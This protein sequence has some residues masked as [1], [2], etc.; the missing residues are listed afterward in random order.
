M[1]SQ[2]L[3]NPRFDVLFEPVKIG[4]VTAPNRFYQV[5]HCTGMGYAL[6]QTL[7]AMRKV[8]AEGGWG[9]VCTEYTSIDPSSDDSPFPS[10]TLWDEDD[11]RTMAVVA[12]VI[13]EGG[14]LAGTQLWHGGLY[15]SNKGSRE[16]PIAPSDSPLAPLNP[17][18]A[19]A[20]DKKDIKQMRKWQVDAARRAQRAGFDIV[21]VYAGHAY[22]PFQFIAPRFNRRTDEYG[23]SL[24]NRVRL[25]REMIEETKE[26]IGDTCAVAVRFAVHEFRV[27]AGLTSDGEGREVVEMLA[28]H[29]DLWDV[30]IS[31][32]RS[33]SGTSRFF[34]EGSQEQ[35]TD[36]VKGVT[37]K[38]V[39]GVGRYTSPD[40]MVSTIKRGV[41]DLI[42]AA[43]PSIADPF[44]PNKIDTGREDEIRECI[45]CNI[46][47][48]TFKACSPIRC[49]QNPTMGEEYRRGWHP[50]RIAAKKSDEPVLIIGSG[51]AGLECAMALGDRGYDV[52]MAETRTEPGGHIAQ[53]ARLPG[54]AAWGR[55]RDYRMTRIEKMAN[56]QV[57]MESCMGQ[58]EIIE[59]GCSRVVLAIGSKWRADGVG[60][61]NIT[62]ID[63]CPGPGV[64]TPEDV[65]SGVKISDPVIIF[66][67]EHYYM[68]GAL[69]EKL[70]NE[71]HDV[72]LV[73]TAPEPC[74]WTLQT[75]EHHMIT[76]HLH[77]IGVKIIVSHNLCRFDGEEVHLQF[78]YRGAQQSLPCQTLILTTSRT[79]N[80]ALYDKML[81]DISRTDDQTALSITRI[82]DCL[83]PGLTAD[84]IYGGHRFAEELDT[85]DGAVT[86]NRERIVL[87]TPNHSSTQ[88]EP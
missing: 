55:V 68:G 48:A 81:D 35:Y 32:F 82:G 79:P 7:A 17:L 46:C 37:S 77:E 50:D 2:S 34:P 13:H 84:A 26:A 66:D 16:I 86:V 61:S 27:N 39:V 73:T 21:Y 72:T 62:A 52:T 47:R 63:G 69:A 85:P 6:P 9:V 1:C 58:S 57:Y 71:G 15:A 4:P 14:S 18:H 59:F 45:G 44:L 24:E 30:N 51:P 88:R 29:P 67:D 36:F 49:T 76:P 65:F 56:V 38:P 83:A 12:D 8:K 42:G 78:A 74:V 3:R 33:D 41:L 11:V 64:L 20:M 23:G 75:D 28:E 25:F 19:R 80:R 53:A 54:F 22:L 5:P 60:R 70:T 87:G 40:T 43:R 31:D 10:C